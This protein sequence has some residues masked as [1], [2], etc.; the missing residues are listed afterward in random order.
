MLTFSRRTEVASVTNEQVY[1]EPA[2][3]DPY[4][5]EPFFTQFKVNKGKSKYPNHAEGGFADVKL[6]GSQGSPRSFLLFQL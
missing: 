2:G 6:E 3:T 4:S 5:R 1:P